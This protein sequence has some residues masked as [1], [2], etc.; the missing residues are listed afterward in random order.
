MWLSGRYIEIDEFRDATDGLVGG[1]DYHERHFALA[2][3]RAG[4]HQDPD[5]LGV[6]ERDVGEV[7]HDVAV[8]L[9][10]RREELALDLGGVRQVELPAEPEQTRVIATRGR[11]VAELGHGS[12]V[13]RR[14]VVTGQPSRSLRR[15]TAYQR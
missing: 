10:D 7:D 15:T 9:A 13:T 14:G 5:Q 4:L 11:H 8:L 2:C 6:H 12:N 1:R 3:G